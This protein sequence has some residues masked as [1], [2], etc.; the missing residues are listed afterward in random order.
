MKTR[1]R[2]GSLLIGLAALH[3]CRAPAPAAGPLDW[4]LG[5]WHGVRSS[6]D[7]GKAAPIVVR[8]EPL[9]EGAGQMER[10]EVSLDPRPYVGFTVRMPG[11]Q[12]GG[13]TMFYANSTRPTV[14]RLEGRLEGYRST[15][16]SVTPGR[17]RESRLVSERLDANHWRRTQFVSEDAGKTWQVLFTDELEPGNRGR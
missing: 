1:I 7:D 15:W 11:K 6:A 2:I 10:L 8:V 3:A 13:W 9:P 5:S 12:S 17:T 14:S 4:A 16:Q